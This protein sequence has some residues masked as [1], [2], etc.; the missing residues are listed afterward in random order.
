MANRYRTICTT[1][2][3]TG[4]LVAG[5]GNEASHQAAAA[6]ASK[7]NTGDSLQKTKNTPQWR[8]LTVRASSYTLAPDETRPEGDQI[9]AF[10]D[11][12]SPEDNVIAVSRDLLRAGLSHGT[13]VRIEGLD[14]TYTVLDKMHR[15][16]KN[17]IDILFAKRRRALKWGVQT[18][19]I[20]YRTTDKRLADNH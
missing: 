4:T 1:L 14:G 12:L 3:I 19:E 17:K 20:R 15:R 5:C 8:R 16:W 13:R 9:G 6:S 7:D 11:K 2:L 10:G 18:V